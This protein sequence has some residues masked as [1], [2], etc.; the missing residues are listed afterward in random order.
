[1]M[2]D[3]PILILFSSLNNDFSYL[4]WQHKNVIPLVVIFQIIKH[5]CSHI[6][7]LFKYVLITLIIKS[8]SPIL[9]ALN[10]L[11][12]MITIYLILLTITYFLFLFILFFEQFFV[13]LL[14]AQHPKLH[15]S[16]LLMYKF[17]TFNRVP[18]AF[19]ISNTDLLLSIK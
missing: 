3:S 5:V 11:S 13:T 1:M 17:I 12:T 19:D 6:I 2:P 15:I 7:G 9:F 4:I 14:S 8:I 10:W 16:K 18:T